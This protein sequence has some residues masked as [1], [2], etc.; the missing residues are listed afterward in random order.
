MNNDE[1]IFNIQCDICDKNYRVE[2]LGETE[3]Y[4]PKPENCP[5]CN[6][7][8]DEMAFLLDG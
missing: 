3:E 8:L 4:I 2:I 6:T 7:V 1:N 5:F